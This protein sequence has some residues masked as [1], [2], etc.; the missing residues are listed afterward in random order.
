VDERDDL[1]QMSVRS[2]LRFYGQI[3]QQLKEREILTTRDGP[4]GGY[5]EWLVARAFGG[6]RQ[7]NSNKS[8][9]VIA[10]DGTRLQVKTR[11]LPLEHDSRQLGA[12]RNLES[13]GFDYIVAVL[14]DKDFEVAEAYQIPHAAVARLATRAEQ[15]NSHRLVLSPKVCRDGDCGD[16]TEKIRGADPESFDIEKNTIREG[17]PLL[18]DQGERPR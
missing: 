1:A 9:D 5:G 17:P 8:V 10:S 3:L 18:A 12:I 16:I 14:L 7:G 4:I 15:T 11:W 13:G 2:L 6:T